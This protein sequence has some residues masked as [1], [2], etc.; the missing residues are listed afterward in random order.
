MKELEKMSTN[1]LLRLK[2]FLET[3]EAEEQDFILYPVRDLSVFMPEHFQVIWI[4][5]NIGIQA[6]Y[7]RLIENPESIQPF[8]LLFMKASGWTPD[9]IESWLADH[10]QYAKPSLAPQPVG[11]Q[12]SPPP[13]Q[14]KGVE[15]MNEKELKKLVEAE[16]KAA[17][18]QAKLKEAE[19]DTEYINN[20]PDSAFAVI[21][22]GGKKDEQGKTVPR[23]LRHL[24]HHNAQDNLDLPHLRAAMARL[25]Q[26][27]PASLQPEAKKHLCGHARSEKAEDLVSQFCGEEPPATEGTPAALIPPTAPLP[28]DLISRKAVIEA[29]HSEG[30]PQPRQI[31]FSHGQTG[32]FKRLHESVVRVLRKIEKGEI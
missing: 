16:V 22:S 21:G 20:L 24:P 8:A 17:L 18:E 4:D 30:I 2:K 7:G 11:V 13:P 5:Q 9:K 10:P 28:D 3:R 32:G 14:A 29:F 26:I 27:E 23:T 25:N 31:V 6:L 12:A 15:T 1:E 19:W